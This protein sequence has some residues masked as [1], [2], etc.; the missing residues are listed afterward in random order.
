MEFTITGNFSAEDKDTGEVRVIKRNVTTRI[1]FPVE[2]IFSHEEV[3]NS[4][5]KI[6]KNRCRLYLNNDLK[7]IVVNRS[8]DTITKLRCTKVVKVIGFNAGN[9]K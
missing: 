7:E 2:D 1:S 3:V 6:L 8:Y 4:R 9:I 5:G